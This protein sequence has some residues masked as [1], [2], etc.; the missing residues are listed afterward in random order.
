MLEECAG[1]GR[2]EE[3][4]RG[5]EEGRGRG[6][7]KRGGEEGRGGRRGREG[8]EG[9]ERVA[10]ICIRT[11]MYVH[12]CLR[13]YV[14]TLAFLSFQYMASKVSAPRTHMRS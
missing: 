12:V 7:G 9:G 13:M 1:R 4:K 8:G 5:G 6:E 10:H 2:W 3:G 11:C 14:H